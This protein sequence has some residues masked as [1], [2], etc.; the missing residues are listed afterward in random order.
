MDR[1]ADYNRHLPTRYLSVFDLM[2]HQIIVCEFIDFSI[3]NV[4]N[5][6]TV[7]LRF[8]ENLFLMKYTRNLNQKYIVYLF[9]F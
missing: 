3:K 8:Y 2:V 1:S 9:F 7:L 6:N 5:R 4:V